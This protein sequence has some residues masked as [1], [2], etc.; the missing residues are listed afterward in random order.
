M[1]KY[2][3]NNT[4]EVQK[5]QWCWI[6][7]YS[8]GTSLQQFD[9][10]D[11]SFH[12]FR[13]IDQFKLASF[14]M[15]SNGKSPITLLFQ[16]GMKLIHFYRNIQLHIGSPNQITIRLYC[17]G[18]QVGNVKVLMAIMPDGSIAVVDD[19]DKIKIN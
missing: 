17:F 11:N 7:N 12:Q 19:V 18:Y 16:P 6:A 8:D 1:T 4:D 5:E 10:S 13:E 15:V 14:S 3:F 2:F 9:D